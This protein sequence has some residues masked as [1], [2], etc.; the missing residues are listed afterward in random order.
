MTHMP[1][2]TA[3]RSAHL[4]TSGCLMQWDRDNCNMTIAYMCRDLQKMR[5]SLHG[6][7][8]ALVMTGGR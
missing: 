3:I 6:Y 4:V 1:Y 7:T 8:M 2:E 5:V